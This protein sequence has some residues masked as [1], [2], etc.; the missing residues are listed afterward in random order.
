MIYRPVPTSA[1]LNSADPFELERLAEELET[2]DLHNANATNG[3]ITLPIAQLT[4]NDPHLT[5]DSFSVEEFLL[6]RPYTSLP[7]LRTEL[8]D[9]LG[10]LKQELVSLIN[11]DYEAFISLSTNLQGEDLRIKRLQHPLGGLREV[12]VV[13]LQWPL[14]IDAVLNV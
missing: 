11:E 8:R 2:R 5:S 6:S 1:S 4:H 14:I 3:E 7:D 9:Y 10:D 13:S 12:V